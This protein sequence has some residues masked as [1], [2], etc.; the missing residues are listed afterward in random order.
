MGRDRTTEILQSSF[1]SIG[2]RTMSIQ[3]S[4]F[5]SGQAFTHS[6]YT[7]DVLTTVVTDYLFDPTA[8]TC[9]QVIAETPIFNATAGPVTIEFFAGTT[10]SANGTELDVFNRRAAGGAAEAKLYVGPTI[11][12]VGTRFAGQILTATDAVQ[13]DTGAVT[14]PGLPFEVD[15]TT[16]ILVRVTNINGTSSIGRRFDWVEV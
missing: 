8:C 3:E 2:I 6:D 9:D 16:L 1:N 14:I 10:V 15:K 12:L 7:L 5:I 4:A 11:T 13:G